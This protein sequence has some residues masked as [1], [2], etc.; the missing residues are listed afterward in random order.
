MRG[1]SL[2]GVGLILNP[3]AGRD[4][5]RLV[6]PASSLTNYERVNVARRVLTGLRGAGIHRVWYLPDRHALVAHAA[7][8]VPD[9]DL[10]SAIPASTDTPEDTLRATSAMVEAG[11]RVLITHGGD[12]TNRLVAMRSGDVPLVPLAA[13]TNNV[14]PFSIEA[15]AA[16]F[17]AGVLA[18]GLVGEGCTYRHK[19]IR[20]RIGER[21]EYALVDAAV[22][23]DEM[24][25]SRAVWEPER[26][27]ACMVTRA[28]PG[29]VGLS[30]LAGA[31]LGVS[32]I[33]P[34]GAYVE[35]GSGTRILALI[36]PGLVAQTEVR[37]VQ[38]LAVGDSVTIGPV[39]GTL[40]LDGERQ[41][42]LSDQRATLMLQADGPR[43]VDVPATLA[44]AQRAGAFRVALP[45]SL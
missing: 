12:G 24:V 9:L 43:V 5:R 28:A 11:A 17:A 44:L 39:R 15:T 16:G 35:M 4:V 7:E 45:D 18:G 41:L 1:E 33:E 8:S 30:G 42:P 21:E 13:G 3:H 37:S 22:L 38:L 29:A 36:A 6:T 20:V 34:V 25:G 23:R 10:V 31:L 2:N 27:I 19:R 40:S 14:F 26:V 32:P